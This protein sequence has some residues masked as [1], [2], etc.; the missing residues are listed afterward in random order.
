MN[1][2]VVNSKLTASIINH[3]YT[4]TTT[5]IGEGVIQP[6]PKSTLINDWKALLDI[7]GLGHS[8]DTTI[9]T[10]VEDTILLEDWTKHVLDDNGWGW[11]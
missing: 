4:N 11:V 3:Q 7:T 5:A 10:H 9:I 8:N 6:G 2:L 1:D